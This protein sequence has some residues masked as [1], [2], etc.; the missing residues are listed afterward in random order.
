MAARQVVLGE[1]LS[2]RQWFGAFVVI[3]AVATPH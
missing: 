1:R 3:G 2:G